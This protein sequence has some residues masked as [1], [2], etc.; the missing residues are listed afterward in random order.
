MHLNFIGAQ[1]LLI[2]KSLSIK[3]IYEYL[4]SVF[5]PYIHYE[6]ILF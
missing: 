2:Y 4:H 3:L 6:I 1:K 5:L